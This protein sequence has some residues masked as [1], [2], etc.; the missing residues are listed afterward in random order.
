MS[1]PPDVDELRLAALAL[2][3]GVRVYPLRS[4]RMGTDRDQQPG[5]VLGYGALTSE[6]AVR[7]T[8]VL[9]EVVS[10]ARP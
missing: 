8:R 2:E 9:G 7:G 10:K 1:L 5:L 4:Y 6:A 3:H